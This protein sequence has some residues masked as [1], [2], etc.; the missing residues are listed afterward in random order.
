MNAP[1][2]TAR[3]SNIGIL[4]WFAA[5]ISLTLIAAGA[6]AF[7]SQYAPER[8]APH[9]MTHALYDSDARTFGATLILLGLSLLAVVATSARVATWWI[10]A[11]IAFALI[12]L[13]VGSRIWG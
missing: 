1:R 6:L 10:A 13:V 4:R 3:S 7:F 9:A 11:T 5:L 8:S 12:N 2:D